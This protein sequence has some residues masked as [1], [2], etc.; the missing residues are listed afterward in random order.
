VWHVPPHVAH[1][2][3]QH[4]L[5]IVHHWQVELLSIHHL[6]STAQHTTGHLPASDLFEATGC[7]KLKL[8]N[9]AFENHHHN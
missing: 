9:S 7:E 6:H 4:V 5:H 3:V 1:L 8:A 2:H